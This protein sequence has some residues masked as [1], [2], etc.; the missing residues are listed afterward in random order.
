MFLQMVRAVRIRD[1]EDICHRTMKLMT[2]HL[3]SGNS[4]RCIE[5]IL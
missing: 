5:L 4:L 3:T 1:S 2:R